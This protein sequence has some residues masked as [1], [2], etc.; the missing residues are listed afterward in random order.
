MNRWHVTQAADLTDDID[1]A[2]VQAVFDGAKRTA[3]PALVGVSAR[4]VRQ[5]LARLRALIG[6]PSWAA[7]GA[8]AH[9]RGWVQPDAAHTH[10]TCA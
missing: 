9:Q 8:A 4:Q 3:L 6:A 5:R 1:R 10:D 7:F 2:L